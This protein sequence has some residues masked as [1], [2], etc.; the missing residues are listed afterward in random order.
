M[1]VVTVHIP[2]CCCTGPLGLPNSKTVF[3][4]YSC[5]NRGSTLHAS[6]PDHDTHTFQL[7]W[8][9]LHAWWSHMS[10]GAFVMW[11]LNR[12]LS[13]SWCCIY[14]LCVCV[15]VCVC[16]GVRNC[17]PQLF[18]RLFLSLLAGLANSL[19]LI[20]QPAGRRTQCSDMGGSSN[21]ARIGL[22]IQSRLLGSH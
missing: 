20:C 1:I 12:A 17:Q 10:R 22:Q 3:T 2:Q 9:S 16:L 7:P 19:F 11:E 18:E 5:V 21:H 13:L 4:A 14:W 6:F 8:Q 15:C